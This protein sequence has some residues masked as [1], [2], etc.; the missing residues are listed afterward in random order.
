MRKKEEEVKEPKKNN[1]YFVRLSIRLL[2]KKRRN[3]W[4]SRRKTK[5][6]I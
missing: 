1:I 3:Y 2:E 4:K 6:F 5:E